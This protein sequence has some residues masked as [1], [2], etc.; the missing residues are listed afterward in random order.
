MAL[1]ATILLLM[2]ELAWASSG[3]FKK[4]VD[5]CQRTA[6]LRSFS[7]LLA[8]S[9]VDCPV[10]ASAP[11]SGYPAPAAAPVLVVVSLTPPAGRPPSCKYSYINRSI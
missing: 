1:V 4:Y 2:G 11:P 6:G 9:R 8:R 7:S 3:K 10:M 5:G